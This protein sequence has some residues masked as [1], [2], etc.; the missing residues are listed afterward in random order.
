MFVTS[1]LHIKFREY[2]LTNGRSDMNFVC[3]AGT[4]QAGAPE[5]SDVVAAVA[6]RAH[7]LHELRYVK[8]DALY[9]AA[10]H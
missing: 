3:A 1:E 6:R 7:R 10:N 8:Y 5:R 9:L 2:A 4:R